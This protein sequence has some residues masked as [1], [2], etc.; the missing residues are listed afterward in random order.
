MRRRRTTV[1]CVPP[2]GDIVAGRTKEH[3]HLSEAR[4]QKGP[5]EPSPI[6]QHFIANV[7]EYA[8]FTLDTEG[9]VA[10]WNEGARAMTGY[11]ADEVIGRPCSIFYRP[12]D[13]VADVPAQGLRQAAAEGRYEIRGLRVRRDGS[14]FTAETVLTA[15]RDPA[16]QLLGF[17]AITRDVSERT[18]LQEQLSASES[19]LRSVVDTV[20]DTLVDGLI[21]IDSKGVIQVYNRACEKLFGYVADEAIG[22]NIIMLMPSTVRAGHNQYLQTYL[23]T[24]IRKIIGQPREV[25]GCRKDGSTFPMYLAVGETTSGGEP[26][27]VG[28]V[29]DLTEHHRTEGELR[30]A[31][32]ME[33]LG[34]LTGGIAHDFNNILMV[35]LANVDTIIED[36]TAASGVQD[37]VRQIDRAAQR[38]AELTR[39]LLAFSRKQALQPQLTNLNDIVASTVR[40]IRR[41]LAEDIT[42]ETALIRDL[43][44]TNVDRTQL[45]S[46]LVNLCIN[47]RDAMPEG[48]RLLLETGNVVLDEDYVAQN[49]DATTGEQVMIAVTDTGA[50]IAPENLDKVFEPFFTTKEIGRG[51]GLG[52]SM[53]Y[54]F[55][56]QSQGHIKVYSETGRGTSI[57]LYL[58]RIVGDGEVPVPASDLALAGGKERILVVEDDPQVRNGVVRQLASLGYAVDEAADGA[59]GLA[60]FA[61][62]Q[63]AYDLLLTD[64]IMPGA[65]SGKSLADEVAR[66][67]PGTPVVFMS[68]Y[69]EEAIASQSRLDPGVR[70]LAKPFRKRD[71]ARMIRA[72]L[73]KTS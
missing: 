56:K 13:V 35:I 70:L 12:E 38:A 58:P 51:T 32:K 22:S 10:D 72:V 3:A 25:T 64:V 49:P 5:F 47:A 60:A 45:E 16:R 4:L 55:I 39:Q 17:G 71:L 18:A 2:P 1:D 26:I 44:T 50:G 65:I 73:D 30:Q 52:L 62:A 63:P 68:G 29:H 53:V 28:V 37:R 36:E 54:G 59:T 8:I 11:E 34:Q 20:L 33:A 40:L 46:A 7:E 57:K 61:A 67:W 66:R 42:V 48:G 24:G 19:R 6:L 14:L 9:R 31:Q 27:Y 21:I 43:W 41:T 15:V 69:T 23:E